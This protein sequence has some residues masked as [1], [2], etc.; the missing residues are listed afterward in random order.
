M[1][2][3]PVVPRV[4]VLCLLVLRVLV[5]LV[6]EEEKVDHSPFLSVTNVKITN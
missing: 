4:L 1:V 5:L 6:Q 2:V 3:D